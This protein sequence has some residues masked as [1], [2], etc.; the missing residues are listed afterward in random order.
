LKKRNFRPASTGIL[1]NPPG[2]QSCCD[3]PF[4][5][6]DHQRRERLRRPLILSDD[7]FQSGPGVTD[8]ADF[9]VHE[10]KRQSD[11]SYRVFGDIG[12]NL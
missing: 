2:P 8:G 3:K 7:Q 4:S 10:T 9:D 12:W 11:I 6:R 5:H 1:H